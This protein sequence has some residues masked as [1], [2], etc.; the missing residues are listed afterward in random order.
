V[1]LSTRDCHKVIPIHHHL[2]DFHE[3]PANDSPVSSNILQ[4]HII[5]A[6]TSSLR[7][8]MLFRICSPL[9]TLL[10]SKEL[11]HPETKFAMT[12]FVWFLPYTGFHNKNLY[13]TVLHVH[14]QQ[15]FTFVAR[16]L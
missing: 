4:E 13:Y 10:I 5:F 16:S 1:V 2:K 11:K 7:R 14:K 12:Y 9:D 6:L 8:N 15:Q 3:A